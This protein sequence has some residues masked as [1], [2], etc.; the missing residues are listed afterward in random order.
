MTNFEM[1]KFQTIPI[2]Y[3]YCFENNFPKVDLYT[4]YRMFCNNNLFFQKILKLLSEK[5]LFKVVH[6]LQNHFKCHC[7]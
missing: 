3:A 1:R 5:H 4:N 6:M 7:L 2:L